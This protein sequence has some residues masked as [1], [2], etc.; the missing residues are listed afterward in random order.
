MGLAVKY[1]FVQKLRTTLHLYTI[2]SKYQH[3]PL[4]YRYIGQCCL[5]HPC[6]NAAR[7]TQ[8]C[9]SLICIHLL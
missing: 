5:L 2:S 6:A 7:S 1:V 8:F 4:K 9:N 3:I